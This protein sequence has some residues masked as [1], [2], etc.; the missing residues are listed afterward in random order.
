MVDWVQVLGDVTRWALVG[1]VCVALLAGC[2]SLPPLDGRLDSKALQPAESAAT[3]LGRALAPE[4]EAH[5][6]LSGI[7]PLADAQDA[8]AARVLLAR[9]AER[10]LDV[11]Y[12]IWRGDMTGTLLFEALHDRQH[13]APDRR[14]PSRLLQQRCVV[15]CFRLPR[16]GGVGPPH[17]LCPALRGQQRE[18]LHASQ[19]GDPRRADDD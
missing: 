17:R 3:P 19:R 18:H 10:T 8:F 5:P 11:Q 9:A 14:R 4:I 7:F 15:D 1:G 12:Y 6:G 16:S 2:K 13:G